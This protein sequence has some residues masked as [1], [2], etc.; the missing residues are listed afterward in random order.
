MSTVVDPGSR[1]ANSQGG[2]QHTILPNFSKNCMKSKE[3]GPPEGMRVPRATLRSATGQLP[4]YEP[5]A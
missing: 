5:L 1:G 4:F 3:F 2:H